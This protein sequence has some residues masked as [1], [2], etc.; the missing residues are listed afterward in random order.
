MSAFSKNEKP[1]GDLNEN[2]V[3]NQVN[4]LMMSICLFY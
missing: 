1:S 2:R 3:L 4:L